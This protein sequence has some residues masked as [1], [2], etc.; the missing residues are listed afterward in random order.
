[1]EDSELL[2]EFLN[3]ND[4]AFKELVSR[5]HKKL[6]NFIWL[7]IGNHD[8]TSDVCQ[9]SF[10]QAYK[11][12]EQF[13]GK[14]SFKSWLYK[15]AIN[16]CKNYYR[17]KERQRIDN[18][19]D[20]DELDKPVHDTGWEKLIIDE[21]KTLIQLAIKKLPSKQRT[22]IELRYFQ[23]CTLLQISEIMDCPVSTA[24]ANYYHALKALREIMAGDNHE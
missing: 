13:H 21:K 23:E 9:N 1:M 5:H 12:A 19:I 8:D 2:N 14:A 22:T 6:Y 17:S 16:L 4:Q 24:K 15:I 3:G 11:K 18:N 20:P 10:I 7:K